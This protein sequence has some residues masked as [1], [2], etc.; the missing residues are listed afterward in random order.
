MPRRDPRDRLRDMVDAARAITSYVEGLDLESFRK[1]RR[2]V[3]AVLRNVTVLGEAARAVPAEVRELGPGT[4]WLDVAD[5][6]NVVVHEYFGVDLDILFRTAT[7]DV[8]A[9]L[10]GLEALLERL[11]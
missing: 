2:T 10:S 5:M 6:R 7:E 11:G 3:D 9:L 1:D 8:P 4:P